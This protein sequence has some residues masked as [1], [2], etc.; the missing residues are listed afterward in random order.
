MIYKLTCVVVRLNSKVK[1]TFRFMESVHVTHIFPHCSH[2]LYINSTNLKVTL[3]FEF[4]M[5]VDF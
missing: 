3:N 5:S 4:D 1:T 2:D